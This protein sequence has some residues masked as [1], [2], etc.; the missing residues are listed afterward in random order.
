MDSLLSIVQMPGGVPVGTLAIGRA[1]AINAACWPPPSWPS[2]TPRWPQRS[3]TGAPADRG[4]AEAPATR[5][6]P[7]MTEPQPRRWRRAP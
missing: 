5:P 7:T 2:R 6:E 1:G 3:T 4:V